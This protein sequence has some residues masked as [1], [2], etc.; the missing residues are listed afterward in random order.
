LVCLRYKYAEEKKS[1]KESRKSTVQLPARVSIVKDP[2]AA[3]DAS[4][5][6]A[7]NDVDL[8]LIEQWKKNAMMGK[9][10]ELEVPS[11]PSGDDQVEEMPDSDDESS[12]KEPPVVIDAAAVVQ[13][14]Q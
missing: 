2:E 6:A 7:I 13:N 14:V 9:V 8:R 10:K 4:S 5:P 11:A 12:G 1:A 3:A